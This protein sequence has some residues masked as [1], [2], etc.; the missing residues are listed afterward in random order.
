MAAP[1]SLNLVREIMLIIG[2]MGV[3]WVWGVILGILSFVA[4]AYSLYLYVGRQHG[5]LTKF[6]GSFM[7][8]KARSFYIVFCH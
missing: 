6:Y 8:V 1:P 7:P 3:G 5:L 4:G 2:V